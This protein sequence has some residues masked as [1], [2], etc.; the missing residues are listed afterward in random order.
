MKILSMI[1]GTVIVLLLLFL[2]TYPCEA[3]GRVLHEK[4]RLVDIRLGL[5][6]L[7]RGP[8]SPSGPSGCTNI[9]GSGGTDCPIKN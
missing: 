5:E 3:A 2:S 6:S 7:Q 8:I 9:P 1:L 4:N